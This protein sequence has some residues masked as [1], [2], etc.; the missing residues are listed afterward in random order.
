ML[1][2]FCKRQ[3]GGTLAVHIWRGA[4][5]GTEVTYAGRV[6]SLRE[7]NGRDDSDFYALVWDD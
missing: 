3:R 6:L 2:L 4:E 1:Y 5:E 7:W